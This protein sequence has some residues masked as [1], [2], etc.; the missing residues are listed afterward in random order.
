[1]Y[2]LDRRWCWC[3]VRLKTGQI[4]TQSWKIAGNLFKYQGKCPGILLN[5]HGKS[6]NRHGKDMKKTWKFNSENPYLSNSCRIPTHFIGDSPPGEGKEKSNHIDKTIGFRKAKM[7]VKVPFKTPI[8]PSPLSNSSATND[9]L[10]RFQ[11][12]YRL[13]RL[14]WKTG[15]EI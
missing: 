11:Y 12:S 1:M 14:F 7:C 10:C 2:T 5:G 6:W 9:Y 15:P 3:H 13:W 8:H 4:T